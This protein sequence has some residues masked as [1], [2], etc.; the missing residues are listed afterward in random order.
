MPRT[1]VMDNTWWP[2]SWCSQSAPHT[3][4]AETKF[5]VNLYHQALLKWHVYGERNIPNPGNNPYFSK[6]FYNTIKNAIDKKLK[7]ETISSKELYHFLL[8]AVISEPDDEGRYQSKPCRTELLSPLNNWQL[9]W[10]NARLKGL[11]SEL[12]SGFGPKLD[13]NEKNEKYFFG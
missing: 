13:Q 4:C 1:R 8:E 3:T 5:Q 7:I 11:S 9:T 10:K 6:S 2:N 12:H